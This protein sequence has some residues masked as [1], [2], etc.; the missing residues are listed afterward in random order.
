MGERPLLTPSKTLAELSPTWNGDPPSDCIS[1]PW[2]P[3]ILAMGCLSDLDLS[4]GLNFQRLAFERFSS[5]VS[6]TPSFGAHEFFLVACFGRFAICL[7]EDSI[8]LMLQSCLGAIDKDF[9]VLHMSGNMFRFSAFS[10]DI[11]FMIYRLHSFKCKSI[12]MFFA[13]WGDGAPN[14]R[15]ELVNWSY[16]EEAKWFEPKSSRKTFAQIVQQSHRLTFKRISYPSNYYQK[17]YA[18][19]PPRVLRARPQ[20]SAHQWI[21]TD[22]KHQRCFW[23]LAHDHPISDCR[24]MIH[25]RDCL[26]YDH[27]SRF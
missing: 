19:S 10:K 24:F 26:R 12:D 11:G 17:N 22:G 25:Y 23:C 7:S 16:E 5:P 27:I 1:P 2:R 20:I 3:L 13:L 8:G 14:W 4:L 21:A 18:S 15:P 9:K 6:F